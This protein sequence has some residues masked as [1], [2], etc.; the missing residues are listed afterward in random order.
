MA[1]MS[2]IIYFMKNVYGD[3]KKAAE[4]KFASAAF[5]VYKLHSTL[6]QIECSIIQYF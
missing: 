2:G 4:Q 3:N 5:L 6:E 1:L